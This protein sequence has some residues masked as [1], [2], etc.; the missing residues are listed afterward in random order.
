[1]LNLC[2]TYMFYFTA[3]VRRNYASSVP[4]KQPTMSD[5]PIPHGSWKEAYS[6]KQRK[7]NLHLLAGIVVTAA[8]F[9]YVSTDPP[10]YAGF[11]I[12][13]P[14]THPVSC[15]KLIFLKEIITHDKRF[16]AIY[17][18]VTCNL[19]KVRYGTFIQEHSF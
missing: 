1:M 4:V 13:C 14:F 8:T 19:Q 7:Y 10:N 15:E 9:V 2:L 17:I 5:L 11:S 6:A 16:R 3:L 18:R 12:S